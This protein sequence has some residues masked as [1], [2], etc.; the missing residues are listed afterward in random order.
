MK[1]EVVYTTLLLN[2][3]FLFKIWTE[4]L[5]GLNGIAAHHCDGLSCC[6]VTSVLVLV[7]Q[8]CLTPYSIPGSSV[9]RIFQARTLE[10]VAIS[11]SR[12]SSQPTD[13]TQVSCI[14]GSLFT[15]LSRVQFSDL[16]NA[17][18]SCKNTIL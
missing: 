11:F 6:L 4:W 17:K 12:E 8:S 15:I 13:W 10:W 7:T 16:A 5:S 14:A 1:V 2:S 3:V 9:H 18:R